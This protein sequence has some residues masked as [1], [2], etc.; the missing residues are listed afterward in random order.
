M[1]KDFKKSERPTDEEVEKRLEELRAKLFA[2]QTA[3]RDHKLPVLVVFEG[4]GAAGKGS[5]LGKLFA[6]L[7]QDFSRWQRCM[8]K[9]K[10]SRESLSCTG[11][12]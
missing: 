9:V 6:T 4:W 1:L 12:L 10:M 7:T 8:P 3:I 2:K 11:T 5:I